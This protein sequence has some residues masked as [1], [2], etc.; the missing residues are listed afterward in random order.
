MILKIFIIFESNNQPMLSKITQY[1]IWGLVY[2]QMQN[3]NGLMPGS[4]EI[5]K[6]IDIPQ[7]S[8]AK[9]LQQFV[10]K[11]FII[12]VKGKGGGFYFTNNQSGLTLKEVMQATGDCK[13]LTECFLGI[14]SCSPENPCPVH[15]N[16]AKLR[17]EINLLVSYATIQSLARSNP[18]FT[19]SVLKE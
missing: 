13:I 8:V 7:M 15:E 17:T 12:S 5:A 14:S 18:T 2:I 6:E 19:K 1:A 9:I 3:Y 4:R 16:W 10:R 11:G